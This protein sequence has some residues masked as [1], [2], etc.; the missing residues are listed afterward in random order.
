[1][2]EVIAEFRKLIN[3]YHNGTGTPLR[4]DFSQPDYFVQAIPYLLTFVVLEIVVMWIKHGSLRGGWSMADSLTSFS[5]GIYFLAHGQVSPYRMLTQGMFSYVYTKIYENYK[6]YELPWSSPFT[7]YV[8]AISVDFCYY[9]IHRACHEVNIFWAKHQVHH[10]SDYY[11]LTTA[12]RLSAFQIWLAWPFY[13]P[14]AFF[15]PPSI[16]LIHKQFNLLYQF[17]IH[18]ELID[19]LGPLEYVLNTPKHHRVHHGSNRYC[20][21]KNFGG[22]LIIWD[23]MF[24]TFA[25]ERDQEKIVYGL[26]EEVNSFNPFW[27]HFF[28]Y[29]RI[30]TRVQNQKSPSDKL[31]VLLKGP[32]WRRGKPRLG[33]IEDVPVVGFL[34]I[35]A[36]TP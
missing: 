14:M 8:A 15:V 12:L 13:L 31:S 32:A 30:W 28:H 19:S 3:Q 7:W 2:A 9:W 5:H 20:I 29:T 27:L 18:T 4:E 23:R 36:L 6:I 17:W 1:M 16:L 22:V 21:D 26:V 11:N 24:N 25:E 35:S 33:E 34:D 10:S